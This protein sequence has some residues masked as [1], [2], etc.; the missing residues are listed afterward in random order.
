VFEGIGEMGLIAADR[1]D[2]QLAL[3]WRLSAM[4]IGLSRSARR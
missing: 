4:L 3:L 1:I 2:A